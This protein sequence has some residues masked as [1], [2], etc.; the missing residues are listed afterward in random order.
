MQTQ[1]DPP[2]YLKIPATARNSPCLVSSPSPL[3]PFSISL[4]T[5]CHDIRFTVMTLLPSGRIFQYHMRI[6]SRCINYLVSKGW[7]LWGRGGVW[8]QRPRKP[9]QNKQGYCVSRSAVYMY[10]CAC[11]MFSGFH[12]VPTR[13]LCPGCYWLRFRERTHFHGN[14]VLIQKLY[15]C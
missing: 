13:S 8:P 6:Y 15:P 4:Q 12:S 2:A 14:R 1:F 10:L 7:W 5:D 9:P 11:Y 3:F